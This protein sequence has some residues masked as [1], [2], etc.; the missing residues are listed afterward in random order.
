MARTISA[1]VGNDGVNRK[2]D[3]I[4]V[5]ELLNRVPPDQGGPSPDLVV[6]GLPWQNTQKAI[7]RFQKVQLG[8]KWPDGR[9]DPGGQT[10]AKLNEFDRPPEVGE[11]LEPGPMYYV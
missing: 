6:D 5:Q 10:L 1:S 8:F 4:T 9:V 11:R 3:S 2:D 7:R